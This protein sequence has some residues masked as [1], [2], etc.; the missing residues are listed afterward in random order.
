VRI[1]DFEIWAVKGG[2]LEGGPGASSAKKFL[3]WRSSEMGL[4]TF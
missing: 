2:P 1:L 3:K 4:S